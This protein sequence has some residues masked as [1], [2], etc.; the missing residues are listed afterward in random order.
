MAA[1]GMATELAERID[2]VINF[3]DD[4]GPWST[5]GKVAT[6]GAATGAAGLAG[7]YGVGVM[8]KRMDRKAKKAVLPV[9][10]VAGNIREGY[11]A[12][13]RTLAG[14]L[15]GAAGYLTKGLAAKVRAIQFKEK[16]AY[17]GHRLSAILAKVHR[18]AE[19]TN[20]GTKPMVQKQK[21]PNKSQLARNA[22]AVGAVAGAVGIGG[23]LYHKGVQG[24]KGGAAVSGVGPNITRGARAYAG[25]TKKLAGSAV[26]A[27]TRGARAYAGQTKKLAGSA[28]H[29]TIATGK[30][31][32]AKGQSIIQSVAGKIKKLAAKR[33]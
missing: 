14:G 9:S 30:A 7:L 29:A 8:S 22:A 25:Q 32:H 11:N 2:R 33:V 20:G 24:N 13:K 17:V 3:D 21:N 28:V 5:A 27:I 12:S 15:T 4:N 19:D 1:A 16:N 10:D 26:H 18:F 31:A 23:A 6:A